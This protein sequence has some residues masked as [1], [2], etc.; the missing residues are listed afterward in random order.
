MKDFSGRDI[1]IGDLILYLPKIGSFLDIR[2]GIVVG[3]NKI[4]N[5]EKVVSCNFEYVYIAFLSDKEIEIRQNLISQYN[6]YNNNILGLKK[7]RKVNN[8]VIG[9]I[10]YDKEKSEYLFYL[11]NYYISYDNI[12]LSNKKSVY[13]KFYYRCDD[14]FNVD[15]Y[16]LIH[17]SDIDDFDILEC[18]LSS[19][20]NNIIYK[21]EKNMIGFK[22]NIFASLLVQKVPIILEEECIHHINIHRQINKP[23]LC[24]SDIPVYKGGFY[25]NSVKTIDFLFK[26]L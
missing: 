22:K 1:N 19:K 26:A 14:T 12:V 8:N 23:F 17:K 18:L 6:E 10:Y 9:D 7:K 24:T 4:F 20:Y 2:Y 3:N 25:I 11:G 16:N 15:L 5:G 21:E 13:I